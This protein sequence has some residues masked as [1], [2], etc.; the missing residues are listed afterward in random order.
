MNIFIH[1]AHAHAF[2]LLNPPS[3][4]LDGLV[5]IHALAEV[6]TQG[7]AHDPQSGGP[8]M[9]F[10][11][12]NHSGDVAC[13]THKEAAKLQCVLLNFGH[14]SVNHH[15]PRTCRSSLNSPHQIA[16]SWPQLI[17]WIRNGDK[18]CPRGNTLY[19]F[20]EKF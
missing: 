16:D 8:Q 2:E 9:F 15:K 14:K 11:I 18:V 20:G 5:K 6:V 7:D 17:T 10:N 12:F 19:Y 4:G 3:L 1:A 13:G